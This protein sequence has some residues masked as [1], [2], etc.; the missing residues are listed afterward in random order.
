MT[1]YQAVQA[2]LK[3]VLIWIRIAY[4]AFCDWLGISEWVIISIAGT[5]IGIFIGTVIYRKR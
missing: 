4:T 1:F 5:I 3:E 2:A